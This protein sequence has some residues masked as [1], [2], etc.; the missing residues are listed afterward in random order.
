MTVSDTCMQLDED[1]APSALPGTPGWNARRPWTGAN[2]YMALAAT[3]V[4]TTSLQTLPG[5]Q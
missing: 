5:L 3:N 2:G 4:V 1:G